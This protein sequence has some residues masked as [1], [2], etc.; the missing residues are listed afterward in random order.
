MG[1]RDQ[2][3][4]FRASR[5]REGLV[6]GI[7]SGKRRNV[8]GIYTSV[9]KFDGMHVVKKLNGVM[10]NCATE[11]VIEETVIVSYPFHS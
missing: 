7:V 3:L 6:A 8:V 1:M 4:E 2:R 11:D 9:S 5:G 10:M